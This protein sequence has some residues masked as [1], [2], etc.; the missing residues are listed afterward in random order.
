MKDIH[1]I[2]KKAMDNAYEIGFKC[3]RRIGITD[4]LPALVGSVV[5]NAILAYF[6]LMGNS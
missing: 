1:D 4:M 6:L 3:G 5:L 2:A